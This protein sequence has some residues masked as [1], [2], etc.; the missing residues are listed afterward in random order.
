MYL[1]ISPE[2]LV[3]SMLPPEEFGA[4]LATG[5]HKRPHG[6]AMFFQL[7]QGFKSDYFDLSGLDQRCVPHADGQPKHSLY[8]AIYRVLE[9]IPLDVI[10]S[11]YLATAHGRVLELKQGEIPAEPSGKHHLYQEICPVHPLV[12]SLLAPDEFRKFITDT[13]KPISVPRICFVELELGDLAKDKAGSGAGL[14]YHDIRHIRN[15]LGELGHDTGKRVKTVNRIS[16]PSILFRCIESGFYVG[17]QQGVLY[18][19]YPTREDLAGKYYSWWRCA[20][21]SEID[22]S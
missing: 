14:P 6:Q 20:N 16:R 21:D 13:S 18:Y 22:Y 12:A 4:Y 11:L 2:A 15:C 5:T 17:D 8:I 19:P 10:E 1:S 3:I 9:H 7:K